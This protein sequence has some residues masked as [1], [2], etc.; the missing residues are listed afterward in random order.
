MDPGPV[1]ASREN[2]PVK[3]GPETRREL[4][5]SDIAYTQLAQEV[6]TGLVNN[7]SMPTL[8]NREIKQIEAQV[9]I[10]ME[11]FKE[12]LPGFIRKEGSNLEKTN[13]DILALLLQSY[14]ISHMAPGTVPLL[15]LLN[16]ENSSSEGS[17]DSADSKRR[18]SSPKKVSS[19]QKFLHSSPIGSREPSPRSGENNKVL[20]ER[21][22]P[23]GLEALR[24]YWT[25][26]LKDDR[27]KLECNLDKELDYIQIFKLGDIPQMHFLVHQKL[28]SYLKKPEDPQRLFLDIRRTMDYLSIDVSK[29]KLEKKMTSTPEEELSHFKEILKYLLKGLGVFEENDPIL[30]KWEDSEKE[31][32]KEALVEDALA[33]AG[34]RFIE[35]L[36]GTKNEVKLYKLLRLLRQRVYMDPV[37]A[38]KEVLEVYNIPLTFKDS[39]RVMEYRFCENKIEYFTSLKAS[40]DSS[41][42]IDFPYFEI[43]FFISMSTLK[44]ASEWT[45]RLDF[46]FLLSPK[47]MSDKKYSEKVNK[48]LIEPLKKVGFEGLSI[49]H[50]QEL[51]VKKALK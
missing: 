10:A 3:S 32:R 40:L 20:I 22:S 50:T 39:K 29:D 9:L 27:V 8:S 23:E 5:L 48:C 34:E 15:T 26:K 2:V 6:I 44:N 45:P 13:R 38:V 18:K 33:Y 21:L 7:D 1:V 16:S 51:P 25:K 41:K 46:W 37:D 11:G 49:K 12:K 17:T 47:A 4:A 42:E 24:V 35:S 30:K 31:E 28:L 36:Q 14:L 19:L 43:E